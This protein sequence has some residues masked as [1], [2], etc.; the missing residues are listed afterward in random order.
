MVGASH[1]RFKFAPAAL[2]RRLPR[3]PHEE[4]TTLVAGGKH[5]DQTLEKPIEHVRNQMKSGLDHV[6]KKLISRLKQ[7]NEVLVRQLAN[8][9]HAVF[10]T[11]RPQERVFN[12][13]QYL[14]KYGPHFVE[15]AQ[16]HCDAWAKTL[17]PLPR[18]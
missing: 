5:V 4:F 1:S 14:V 15:Q 11:G 12:I 18:S 2:V 10:P 7:Q 16:D 8:A 13:L 3:L 17:E 9:R 6:E